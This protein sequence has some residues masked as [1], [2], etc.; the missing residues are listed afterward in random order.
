M[1]VAHG[2]VEGGAEGAVRCGLRV[3]PE[4]GAGGRGRILV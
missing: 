1:R 4:G 2:G 3:R